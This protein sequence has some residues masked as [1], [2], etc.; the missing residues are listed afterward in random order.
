MDSTYTG[1]PFDDTDPEAAALFANTGT[2]PVLRKRMRNVDSASAVLTDENVRAAI[3]ALQECW[4]HD[5]ICPALRLR[6]H[7]TGG[8]SYYVQR[9]EIEDAGSGREFLGDASEFTIAQAREKVRWRAMGV[10]L[11]TPRKKYRRDM[12]INEVLEK[13]FQEYPPERSVWFRT[14]KTLF[15]KYI[16]PRYGDYF[17][18]GIHKERW[19]TLI[20]TAAL[21]LPSRGINLHKGLRS[22]L[23]W[24][25][26]R[27][28]LQTNALSRTKVELPIF[29]VPPNPKSLSVD[30]LCDIFRA[31]QDLGEPWST[32]V[33]LFVLTGEAMEHVRHVANGN[34]DWDT[35]IWTPERRA[36]PKWTVQLSPEAVKLLAPYRDRKNYFF[37]SPRS[38]LPINFY[39]EIIEQLR[40]KTWIPWEWTIRDIRFAVRREIEQ[41]GGDRNALMLWSK[42]FVS[43]CARKEDDEVT[44]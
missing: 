20:E 19:L 40:T 18:A 25:I 2:E 39:T 30:N 26:T 35:N 29:E 13:Y 42:N 24:S 33:A 37:Q 27:G 11:S 22:F 14:T 43:L 15:Y 9:S 3:P 31:A 36:A 41:L 4:V 12:R 6:V 34:I 7:P 23:N 5:V 17:L 1:L 38:A 16:A 21:D 32:M 10:Y 28:L 44:L 8:K